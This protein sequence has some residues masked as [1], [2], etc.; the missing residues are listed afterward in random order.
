M[1]TE[2]LRFTVPAITGH[3]D[4]LQ[5]VIEHITLLNYI[6]HLLKKE[7]KFI[8]NTLVNIEESI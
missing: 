6:Y 2:S 7:Q 3:G 5:L 1:I 4:L 8:L